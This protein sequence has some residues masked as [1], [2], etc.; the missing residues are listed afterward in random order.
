MIR[1]TAFPFFLKG[2][3]KA[4]AANFYPFTPPIVLA[5]LWSNWLN[6][7]PFADATH[8]V[9]HCTVPI[10]TNRLHHRQ[11]DCWVMLI[12]LVSRLVDKPQIEEQPTS[13][14]SVLSLRWLAIWWMHSRPCTLAFPFSGPLLALS[15]RPERCSC[16][17]IYSVNST[18]RIM[19]THTMLHSG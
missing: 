10:D 8:C 17:C 9:V 1:V 14:M 18:C 11:S 7:F 19:L 5:L 3:R 4:T 13:I 12:R 15:L 6:C 2:S 16:D